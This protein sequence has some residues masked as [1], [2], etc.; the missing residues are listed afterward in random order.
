[1]NTITVQY[2]G[3]TETVSVKRVVGQLAIHYTPPNER[4]YVPYGGFT[5]WTLSHI[6]SGRVIAVGHYY[7]S[8]SLANFE[9][10]AGRLSA[11]DI[12]AC[13][14][15][16]RADQ[17]VAEAAQVICRQ[18]M[19]ELEAQQVKKVTTRQRFLAVSLPDATA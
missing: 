11:L 2:G 9:V 18:W 15:A 17:A 7:H 4:G 13:W 12:D 1:M 14:D 16:G 5:G 19:Q 8:P 3:K 10:L 6:K